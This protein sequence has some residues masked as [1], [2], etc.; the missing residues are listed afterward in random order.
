MAHASS[1]E[2]AEIRRDALVAR[3]HERNSRVRSFPMSYQQ[4]GIWFI[5]QL[6]PGTPAYHVPLAIEVADAREPDLVQRALDALV[7]H[8]AALRTTF[9]T[10]ELTFEPV[11]RVHARMSV[12]M[13]HS[14]LRTH[15]D[16][17]AAL[18]QVSHQH[19]TMPFDLEA[20][21]LIRAHLLDLPGQRQRLLITLHHLIA[22]GWSLHLLLRDLEATCAALARHQ[23]P[24][25]SRPLRAYHDWASWQRARAT[26]GWQRHLDY[27]RKALRGSAA[28][29]ALPADMPR[30]ASPTLRAGR[31]EWT[32]P[33]HVLAGLHARARQS[34]TTLYS[35]LVACLAIVLHRHSG[36]EKVVIG[37]PMANRGAPVLQEIVG[38]FVN[39]GVIPVTVTADDTTASLTPQVHGLML[40]ALSFQDLPFERLVEAIAPSRTRSA[41]PLFQVM[42]ALQNTPDAWETER[43]H[44]PTGAAKFDL[45]FDA[46]ESPLGLRM[47]CV[48]AA[49]LFNHAT[50]IQLCDELMHELS[51]VAM[52]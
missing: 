22:D 52:G 12:P 10:D 39:I 20:G 8:H 15:P 43:L 44:Q 5:E 42:L 1:L 35:V 9:G 7:S 25:L 32:V 45:T 33:R 31:H 41:H 23:V 30:P 21:P 3:L 11:Q 4:L 14:E 27:Y 2:L 40:S 37:T 46:V 16:P 19:A 28:W 17:G 38:Y 49:E 47:D 24:S 36:Q 50:V 48:Y 34:R 29:P 18:R 6:H 51:M 13:R 26:N